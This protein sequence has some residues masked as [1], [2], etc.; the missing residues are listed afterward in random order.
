MVGLCCEVTGLAKQGHKPDTRT[1]GFGNL[2]KKTIL[3]L[4]KYKKINQFIYQNTRRT[5]YQSLSKMKVGT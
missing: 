3:G 4:L 5:S 2:N 1:Q